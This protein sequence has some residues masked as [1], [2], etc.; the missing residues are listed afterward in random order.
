MALWKW[1]DDGNGTFV[2]VN[3]FYCDSILKIRAV[4]LENEHLGNVDQYR[5]TREV[6]LPYYFDDA[7]R[8]EEGDDL[9]N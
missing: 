3:T 7:S 8:E 6:P 4:R 5:I 2:R 9:D 1:S